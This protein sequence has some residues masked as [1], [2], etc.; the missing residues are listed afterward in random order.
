MKHRK[1]VALLAA[2]ALA[3][4]STL[5]M[6]TAQA[7]PG[8][9]HDPTHVVLDKW[10]STDT[11][12]ENFTN[13]FLVGVTDPSV[14]SVAYW[15]FVDSSHSQSDPHVSA[16][17]VI[18]NTNGI[19]AG[20]DDQV[21]FTW[22]PSMGFSRNPGGNNPGWVVVTPLGW[23]LV[24]A[25]ITPL[26]DPSNYVFTWS[27]YLAIQR[28]SLGMGSLSVTVDG[29]VTYDDATYQPV[30]QK[31]YQPVWQKSYQPVWQKTYQPFERP[32]FA[33]KVYSGGNDT[34]VSRLSYSGN[35][36]AATPT[37]GGTFK[38]GHTY[39]SLDL[40][41]ASSWT[42]PIADSS[43]NS[44]DKKT[45]DQY[46][47][48]VG[49]EYN[50]NIV[51]NQVVIS[52]DDREIS[53]SVGAYVSCPPLTVGKNGKVGDVESSFPG[54][55]PKHTSNGATAD[56]PAACQGSD[57]L[58]LYTHI[59]GGSLKWYAADYTFTGWAPADKPPTL[60]LDHLV[61]TDMTEAWVKDNL[62]SDQWIRDD[63]A[64]EATAPR[65]IDDSDVWS[66]TVTNAA[67]T[68]VCTGTLDDCGTFND[69]LKP[70]NYTVT[71][72]GNGI[73]EQKTVAVP[74]ND[75]A[76]ASFCGVEFTVG[77]PTY[78][79]P[80]YDDDIFLGKVYMMPK[81]LD[82]IYI[83]PITLPALQLGDSTDP[84]GPWAVRTN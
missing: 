55:A 50:V 16:M 10:A 22:D 1:I 79:N 33:K 40:N 26:D 21:T 47:Q 51:G 80:V 67:G 77:T 27:G 78:L 53:A 31:T 83:D 23:T 75:W 45:P 9:G 61:R 17:T 32:T 59:E 62:V 29:Q 15:H 43:S 12:I 74:A 37:N 4:T 8:N 7:N 39:V 69:N 11:K 57:T 63:V 81:I 5:F 56:I 72:S 84:F 30:W 41:A 6:S 48:P 68:L 54:N 82:S 70:G 35:T 3:C 34:L 28:T 24:D 25:W 20:A 49:Y 52:F 42:F 46:N 64:V 19:P 73:N 2:A 13:K 38:N 71:L 76:T 58:Y 14:G 44:N 36:A 18:F 66:V 65:P 60:V